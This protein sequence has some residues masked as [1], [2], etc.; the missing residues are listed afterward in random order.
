MSAIRSASS[1]RASF[2]TFEKVNLMRQV[3][4][5]DS[6]TIPWVE[7]PFFSKLIGDAKLD[8]QTEKL[9]RQYSEEGY[10]IVDTGLD[11]AT[12]DALVAGLEGRFVGG[13]P[14]VAYA[15]ER[16]IQDAWQFCEPVRTVAAL[17]RILELLRVFYRRAP[18]PFQTL[19]FRLGS[20]QR[21]HS[22]TVHF[23]CFPHRFMCGVWVA[24]EDVDADN[25][26]LR[27]YPGSHRLP[28]Y[29]LHD[30]GMIG[31]RNSHDPDRYPQY[32]DFV[33]QMLDALGRRPVEIRVKRG[34]AIIWAANLFHGGSPIR[35]PN[36]T[37]YT[38]ATHYY[39][40]HCLYYTPKFS[41]L[42]LGRMAARRM[43]DIR[44]GRPIEQYY[45]GA[46]IRNPGEWPPALGGE[47]RIRGRLFGEMG[48]QADRLLDRGYDYLYRLVRDQ[49]RSRLGSR[50][51]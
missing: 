42:A 50:A 31:S 43:S 26:P 9:V 48:R 19:N 47:A 16:R 14:N 32:E 12:M 10:V 5:P 25:G 28:V 15:D 51:G 18:I 30:L 41:D 36:R 38:Q 11:S 45:A 8:P 46:R 29:D 27:Y 3:W 24:L 23:H 7:S 22:D 4:E 13:Q 39:F 35:D 6:M 44:D 20:E 17:P 1:T 33:E 34:Q 2:T 40:E 49:I 21:T 37:R